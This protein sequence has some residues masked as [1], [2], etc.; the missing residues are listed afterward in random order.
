MV[1][2]VSGSGLSV[3][4]G[5]LTLDR[6][7]LAPVVLESSTLPGGD[8]SFADKNGPGDFTYRS[9][10]RTV[11]NHTGVDRLVL[12]ELQ[13]RG[14]ETHLAGRNRGQIIL[15]TGGAVDA[16]PSE[17]DVW[18]LGADLDMGT[19]TYG[20]LGSQTRPKFTQVDVSESFS[21]VLVP[22]SDVVVPDGSEL[23]VSIMV[24]W[25]TEL[26]NDN[27]TGATNFDSHNSARFPDVQLTVVGFPQP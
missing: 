9:A 4:N 25:R 26:W 22:C 15:S 11:A 14:G 3:R 7:V 13:V 2:C 17:H 5:E 1:E 20:F 6:S 27:N 24:R 18:M 19:Y 16:A 10:T 8:R 23:R 21:T 12:P